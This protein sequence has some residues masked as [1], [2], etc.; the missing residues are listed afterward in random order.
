[1]TGNINAA[2]AVRRSIEQLD[3]QL[4]TLDDAI[5]A[6][7]IHWREAAANPRK[8]E[9]EAERLTVLERQR[10]LLRQAKLE[11]EQ[12]LNK[13]DAQLVQDRVQQV[14]EQLVAALDERDKL[15]HELASAV[16]HLAGLLK[17]VHAQGMSVRRLFQPGEPVFTVSGV[18]IS[19]VSM[20]LNS[21]D[22]RYCIDMV[23]ADRLGRDLWRTATTPA[24][25][26]IDIVERLRRECVPVRISFEQ[27]VA[28]RLAD[29]KV[30]A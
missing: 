10:D 25:E 8:M 17:A 21:E 6:Q 24:S 3:Q 19:Q 28:A 27:G 30:A 9:H 14:R 22:L 16:D 26:D 29:L 23:L 13:G 4:Q 5:G 2:S 1:M 15:G 20:S 18:G 11:A 12:E 7:T